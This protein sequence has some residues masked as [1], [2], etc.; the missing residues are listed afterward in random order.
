MD[1]SA[2]SAPAPVYVKTPDASTVKTPNANEVK[3]ADVQ[4]ALPPTARACR[5]RRRGPR[6]PPDRERVSTNWCETG[7]ARRQPSSVARAMLSI[8]L[9]QPGLIAS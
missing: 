6:C 3:P 8:T 2:V 7:L 4:N 1:I 9:P 5:S